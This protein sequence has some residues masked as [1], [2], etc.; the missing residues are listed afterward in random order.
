MLALN[1][2][3][4]PID[5]D[6]KQVTPVERCGDFF[7]KRDD[8]WVEGRVA[9]GGKARTAGLI[10][11]RLVADK[12]RGV[13]IAIGRNSSVPGMFS[14]V[15]RHYGLE[16]HVHIPEGKLTPQF[17]EAKENGA[18]V[19][20]H[21]AGY[22]TVLR[23]KAYEQIRKNRL[24]QFIGI[25]LDYPPAGGV[26]ACAI[27]AQNIPKQ[28]RRIVVPVGSGLMLKGVAEGC[29]KYGIDK[30]IIGVSVGKSKPKIDY[31]SF[32]K[33]VDSTTD[34]NDDVQAELYDEV[35]GKRI[36]LDPTYEAKCFEFL[37]PDDL[38][39]IV[40]HRNTE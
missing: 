3:P 18:F 16:L 4:R 2:E 15:C 38:M 23:S 29:L 24:L 17:D 36:P 1:G 37:Q 31:P 7:V 33:L 13:V 32:V 27:Q 14:R 40:C 6:D 22:M 30:P 25:G 35:T 34:F 21:K 19:Y 12:K 9:R 20:Q 39:W 28:A 26:D 8:L 5:L 10:C 11:R